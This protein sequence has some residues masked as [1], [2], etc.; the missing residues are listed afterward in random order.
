VKHLGDVSHV[1]KSVLEFSQLSTKPFL[2]PLMAR[3]M[4]FE[5]RWRIYLGAAL[6]A[7][8]SSKIVLLD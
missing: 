7:F 4:R 1:R 8:C 6:F 2:T 5:Q 3:Q